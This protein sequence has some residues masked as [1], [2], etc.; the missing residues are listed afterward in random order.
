MAIA[1]LFARN[2]VA[3]INLVPLPRVMAVR[4]DTFSVP[5]TVAIYSD[6]AMS[7]SIEAQTTT[8][9][10]YAVQTLRQMMPPEVERGPGL[11]PPGIKLAG[12]AITDNKSRLGYRGTMLD[13]ARHF[14]TLDYIRET[15]ERMALLKLNVLHLH[16][17]DDQGWRVE[18]KSYPNL[19]TVGVATQVGGD[20]PPGGT[21]WYYT[22]DEMKALV[23]YAG[24][25]APVPRDAGTQ[26]HSKSICSYYRY[27]ISM[28]SRKDLI[29]KY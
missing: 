12:V 24:A 13:V 29:R 10:F 15:I 20:H 4:N 1:R 16:L 27:Q 8:G 14:I 2:A 3:A 28:Q 21:R 7:D 6:D 22:Q 5:D 11:V 17:T 26:K 9:Q 18:I 23:A 25:E 19:I